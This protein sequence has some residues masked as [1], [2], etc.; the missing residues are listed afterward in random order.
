[1]TPTGSP[2]SSPETSTSTSR[3]RRR[4]ER[5]TSRW[6]SLDAAYAFDDSDHL[7]R[8]FD[9]RRLRRPARRLRGRDRRAHARRMVGRHAAVHRE[10]ADPDTRRTST[11]LRMRFPELPAV[12]DERQGARSRTRPRWRTRSCSSRCSRARST[13]RRTRSSTSTRAASQEVQDYISMS[14]HQANSNL[15]IIGQKWDELSDEQQDALQS[16]VDT[17]VEQVPGCVEE[18]EAEDARRVEGERFAQGR[19]RRRR[20]GVP[21]EGRLLPPGQLQRR[22][23]GRLRGDPGHG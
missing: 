3:A 16:A 5:S 2:R 19:R 7:A 6:P 23:A 4:S 10:Q 1:M 15:V 14:T 9:E 20:R 13:A 12:P 17:A 22:A 21:H 18:D 8:F 11:G